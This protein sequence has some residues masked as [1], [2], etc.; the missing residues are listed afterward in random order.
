MKNFQ[1]VVV[2][3]LA[4]ASIANAQATRETNCNYE[5]CALGLAP[6]WNGLAVTRGE[7]QRKV[8]VLGFFWPT[9]VSSVFE[10][11]RE[12]TQAAEDA[13]SIRQVGAIL[14]DA[15]LVM[16]TTGVARALFRR[17]WDKLATGLTVAGGVSLGASVPFQ[18]G[19]D[20]YLSRAVWF[21]NRRYSK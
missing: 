9:D 18:F 10:G 5:R 14:T 3:T 6:V 4:L 2:A 17:D 12:A 20:G 15:G 7:E 19:A 16:A 1:F 11:D 8:R 13:M 21:F